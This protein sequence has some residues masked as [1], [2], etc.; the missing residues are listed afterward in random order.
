MSE[1][2][3]TSSGD[4]E[5]SSTG[6]SSEHKSFDIAQEL[7]KFYTWNIHTFNRLLRL[8]VSHIARAYNDKH[9]Y[10][11]QALC[12]GTPVPK[13]KCWNIINRASKAFHVSE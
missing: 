3:L 6:M 11:T 7:F 10:G 4:R 5:A 9:T 1:I 8:E 2:I 12:L 13:Q